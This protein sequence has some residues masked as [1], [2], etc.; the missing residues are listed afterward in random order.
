MSEKAINHLRYKFIFSA[1]LAFLAV[2]LFMGT[3]IYFMNLHGTRAQIKAVLTY[4][5]DVGGVIP[6]REEAKKEAIE[7]IKNK[8]EEEERKNYVDDLFVTLFHTGFDNSSESIDSILFFW[9][10]YDED[11]KQNNFNVERMQYISAERAV[12][13]GNKVI[14]KNKTFGNVDTFFYMI[15]NKDKGKIVVF[16]DCT[17]ILSSTQRLLN[18]IL[19]FC[20]LG[21][22]AAY[23]LV[24]ILSWQMIAPE[25]KNAERQKQFL[26]NA[27]HE[28]K[29]PLSVIRANTE[30]DML[31]N[32]ENDWNKSTLNQIEH[33]TGLIQ[34]LITI[35]KAEEI[36]NTES[37]IDVN[38][39]NVMNEVVGN[40]EPV[41]LKKEIKM[42]RN[43]PEN[44]IFRADQAKMSQLVTLLIDN[45]IK[46]CDDGGNIIVT[47]IQKGKNIKFTVSNDYKDGSQLDCSRFFERFYRADQSHNIDKG[48]YGIGLSIAESIVKQYKGDIEANWNNG[49]ICFIC[50]LKGM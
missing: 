20:F 17:T 30:L 36:E 19:L 21:S 11:G 37:L 28:L 38:M 46:Y 27:G 34:N 29:T 10:S 14:D 43:I 31:M 47:L 7:N 2:M 41:A 13:Y 33:L 8:K 50:S 35:S 5:V 18:I 44:I 32:G 40:F 25:I 12:E 6:P 45:A 23:V 39:S 49:V 42:E 24:R 4:L 15:G 22:I 48:G 9:V 16:L 3:A 26:T 1:F